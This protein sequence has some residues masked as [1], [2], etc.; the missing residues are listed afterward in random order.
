MKDVPRLV[1]AQLHIARWAD[2]MNACEQF[3]LAGLRR[4]VGPDGD[5][6]AAHR[7]WYAQQMEEHDAMMLHM[8][9]EFARRSRQYGE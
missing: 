4:K 7:E 9:R 5:V 2:L 1:D 3:L 6:I 8:L